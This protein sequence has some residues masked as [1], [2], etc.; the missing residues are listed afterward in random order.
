MRLEENDPD[1]LQLLD[2]LDK[3][4]VKLWRKTARKKKSS[5]KDI[6]FIVIPPEKEIQIE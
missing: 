5:A 4:W 6:T 2:E 3:E 1:I